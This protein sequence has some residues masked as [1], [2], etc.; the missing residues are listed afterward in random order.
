MFPYYVTFTISFVDD[1]KT[2][3]HVCVLFLCPI[4]RPYSKVLF[5]GPIPRPYI[6]FLYI[7]QLMARD[8]DLGMR[9]C[10]ASTGALEPVPQVPR[11]QDQCWKQN[12]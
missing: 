12:L 4:P 2:P 6:P 3:I 7:L 9:L 11:S 10:I 8:R 5:Q 1:T